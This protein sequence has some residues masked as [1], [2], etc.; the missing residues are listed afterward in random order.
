MKLGE[1]SRFL[2]NHEYAYGDMGCPPRVPAKSLV[3]FEV[4][5][6]H[7]HD[8][9][10]VFSELFWKKGYATRVGGRRGRDVVE[11]GEVRYE[12]IWKEWGLE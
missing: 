12:S 11:K 9:A 3:L 1:I 10:K 7:F 8:E 6:I 2:I 5:L 4:E